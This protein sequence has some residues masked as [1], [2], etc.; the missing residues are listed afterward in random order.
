MKSQWAMRGE[1]RLGRGVLGP[2]SE[3]NWGEEEIEV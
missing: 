1:P 3:E 2:F